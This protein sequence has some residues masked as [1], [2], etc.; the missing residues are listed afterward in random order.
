MRELEFLPAWYHQSRRW[1]RIVGWQTYGLLLLITA[2]SAWVMVSQ[3]NLRAD[4]QTLDSI[5]KQL[6]RTRV[7]QQILAEKLDLRQKLQTQEELLK[8]LGQQVE[9]TRLL[10]ALDKLMPPEM[11]LVEVECN[12][13]ETPRPV[14]TVAAV[15]NAISRSA[16]PEMDRRLKVRLLGVAPSNSDL[17]TFVAG[18]ASQPF[19]EQVALPYSKNV[20]DSG[21]VLRE[22]SITFSMN[23]N[24]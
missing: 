10:Q 11:S 22:F 4:Q 20:Y 13:E 6:A 3:R 14:S 2:L 12:T 7:D 15:R 8:S 24:Q 9:M 21:H 18:L 19:L 16:P 17:A 23:L 5:E 1:R